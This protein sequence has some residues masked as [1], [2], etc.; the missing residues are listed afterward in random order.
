[1]LLERIDKTEIIEYPNDTKSKLGFLD[2]ILRKWFGN[3]FSDDGESH[4]YSSVACYKIYC[5]LLLNQNNLL[6]KLKNDVKSTLF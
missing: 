4:D 3:P 6:F 5:K 2:S 1:M